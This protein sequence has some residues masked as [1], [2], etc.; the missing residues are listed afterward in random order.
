M[1]LIDWCVDI[2]TIASAWEY[3]ASENAVLMPK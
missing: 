3:D 1:Q 2:N